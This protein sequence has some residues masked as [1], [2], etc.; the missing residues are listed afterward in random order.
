MNL[1]VY[2]VL[3]F[4]LIWLGLS[5]F[6]RM[7]EKI[8]CRT[9][10][11][12]YLK[13]LEAIIEGKKDKAIKLFREV[14]E[15]DP[16]NIES[17][18]YTGNLLREKGEVKKA[19][20]IHK[21]LLVNPLLNKEQKNK[22]KEALAKDYIE[23]K[24]WAKA[25][26]ILETLNNKNPKN[27]VLADE[28]ID[29]YEK[30]QKWDK[31]FNIAKKTFSPE[32]LSNYATYL[33][34]E[35]SKKDTKKANKFIA[36]GEKGNISYAYYLHGKLLV[37][38]GNESEGLELIKKSISIEPDKAYLYLPMLEEYMFKE[39]QFGILE[40]YLKSKFEENPN[41]IYI[42]ASYISILKKRG[43]IERAN[44]ILEES[45]KNFDLSDYKILL[46]IVII[47]N[48]I[49]GNMVSEYLTKIKNKMDKR[50]LFKCSK[51]NTETEEFNWKCNSCGSFGT[52][53][54]VRY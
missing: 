14:L 39:G 27:S 24:D 19:I 46:S 49:D 3:F 12:S 16:S 33:A 1:L 51:C 52:I 20:K 40:P 11:T 6:S 45:I 18:L 26:P 25:I 29:S 34:C 35:V 5:I 28:L 30:L 37:L 54:H 4:A 41:N 50:K 38:E 9:Q 36:V 2:I 42:L 31:A 47:S 43:Q 21:N 17:Y 44:E 23:N 13:G 7:S 10:H 32:K 8:K 53:N 22:L 48:E 15:K